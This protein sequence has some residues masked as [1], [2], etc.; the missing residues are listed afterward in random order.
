M[1]KSQ[2]SNG[3]SINPLTGNARASFDYSMIN[4]T[5]TT[6]SPSY[7]KYSNTTVKGT[8]MQ[9]GYDGETS[10]GHFSGGYYSSKLDS[11]Y[12]INRYSSCGGQNVVYDSKTTSKENIVLG[13]IS[14]QINEKTA[15][16]GSIAMVTDKQDISRTD[17][18]ST[19]CVWPSTGTNTV[20]Y[21]GSASSGYNQIALFGKSEITN[22]LKLGFLLAPAAGGKTN[23]SGDYTNTIFRRGNGMT[24]GVG[25][26]KEDSQMAF[27][28]GIFVEQENKD[29]GDGNNRDLF[30]LYETLFSGGAFSVGYKNSE[31]DKLEVGSTK[32][33]RPISSTTIDMEVQF[34]VACKTGSFC[35]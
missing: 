14:G 35:P 11:D 28:G 20:S 29:S 12:Q 13:I 30:V 26:G 5:V 32:I 25:V 33:A 4:S 7:Y 34:N 1:V 17:T 10:F 27:E 3:L 23:Y 2:L 22:E 9:L 16:A 19:G 15:I 31:S 24:F 6:K 18:A 21:F 8:A